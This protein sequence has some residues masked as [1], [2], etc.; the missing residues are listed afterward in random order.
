[1]DCIPQPLALCFQLG[2]SWFHQ[3]EAVAGDWK[4]GG[5]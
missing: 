1:M 4:E 3:W 2:S 5:E